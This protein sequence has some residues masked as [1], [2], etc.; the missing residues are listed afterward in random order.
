MAFLWAVDDAQTVRLDDPDAGA[1]P[2]EDRSDELWQRVSSG[3]LRIVA[4]TPRAP[5]DAA[6]SSVDACSVAAQRS[7]ERMDQTSDAPL[8]NR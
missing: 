8:R 5:E 2:D 7:E 4:R 1:R 6:R 3:T